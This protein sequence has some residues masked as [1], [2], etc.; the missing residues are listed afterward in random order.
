M[1]FAYNVRQKFISNM[2]H[3]FFQDKIRERT[4]ERIG[5]GGLER[6]KG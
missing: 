6:E 3:G 2:L 5:E 1:Y 4:R